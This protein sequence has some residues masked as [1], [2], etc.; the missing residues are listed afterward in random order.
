VSATGE[1][2][3]LYEALADLDEDHQAGKIGEAD[4]A[5]Q[6]AFLKAAL[7]AALQNPAEAAEA[8]LEGQA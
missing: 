3:A 1:H 7:L 4:Y 5:D 6:R 2:R 8:A